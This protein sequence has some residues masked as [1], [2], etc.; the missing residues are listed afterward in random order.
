M[1]PSKQSMRHSRVLATAALLLFGSMAP[2]SASSTST[3]PPV[4]VLHWVACGD[5]FPGAECA[6]ARVP[7]DYDRP[8]G[9]ATGLALARIPAA[10]PGN[11]IGTVFVNPG[12]PG[13]SGVDLVLFGFG[14]YLASL[15]GGRF[16][17]VGFD[18]RG[19]AASEPLQCFDTEESR[20]AYFAASPVF[21]YQRR[22][23]RPYFEVY[24]G[25][26]GLC[27]GPRPRIAP[28]MSTADV[29]RDLDLLRRAVGDRRLTYLGFSYGTYIGNTYA[30]LFPGRIRALVIDGVLDPR[31]WSSGLQIV[32]D[33]VNTAKE[34]AEFLR[35]CDE[36]AADCALSGSEGAAA[37][38]QA[39]A[40]ALEKEPLD[41]GGG[42]LYTYDFL[43]TDAASAMYTPEFWGGPDGYGA[44]FAF[45]A[46]A[47]LGDPVAA[48]RA[49]ELRRALKEKLREASPQRA[50]Y[51]NG[52]DA[53]YGNACADAEYPRSFAAYH[54]FGR[55]A[56][57]GSMFGPFWWWGNAGCADWPTSA[58]RYAGPWT[59]RT[60]AP[61]LVVGN[62]FDGATSYEGAVA[63]S[64]LLWNSRLLSYAGWGHT[65]FGRSDCVTEHV[66]AYLRDGT[67]PP[68]GTVCPA[69][70][71]PF[72][73][74]PSL[75][76]LQAP[77]APM[78][79]LPPAWLGR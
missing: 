37:R 7:L 39:L 42:F 46:D 10:D 63:S 52:L 23:E 28:H 74:P 27:L 47:A 13:G 70:A 79:G 9:A 76:R 45:L 67:L 62:Y 6:V 61:V 5:Q 14:D 16:D 54:A 50:E 17:V 19:V 56:A 55:Y 24:R 34:F 68:A 33:R 43:V 32:S 18:P 20:S 31:L 4:P 8:V 22:Q 59:T 51:N 77:A 21:P 53:F 75:L 60:S 72:L 40:D 41:L 35:L 26:A 29:A 1:C 36:A 57:E 44:Y 15:L 64:Q 38:F 73:P 2:A 48:R 49:A 69:N 65:A 12:G 25:L 58:D 3:S 30:N 66:V 11:R 78:V 71:N